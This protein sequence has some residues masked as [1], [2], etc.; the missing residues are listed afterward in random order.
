MSKSLFKEAQDK[1]LVMQAFA[2]GYTIESKSKESNN[3]QEDHFPSWNWEEYD[4]RV[5]AKKKWR[6]WKAEEVPVG[7]VLKLKAGYKNRYTISGLWEDNR[8]EK[9]I[10]LG[11]PCVE[12]PMT[13]KKALEHWLHSLD[14]GKTW[15]PCGV[16]ES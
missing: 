16:E 14:F 3:W 9:I 12:G 5:K 11:P 13:P 4:Y 7:A 15:Q 6:P 8:Q 10:Q 1:A 2:A